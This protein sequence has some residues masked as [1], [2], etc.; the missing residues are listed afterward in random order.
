MNREA[1]RYDLGDEASFLGQTFRIK[2]RGRDPRDGAPS[3]DLRPIDISTPTPGCFV[4]ED[5]L[6]PEDDAQ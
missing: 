4:R 6:D 2:G 5:A 1:F 3:Y